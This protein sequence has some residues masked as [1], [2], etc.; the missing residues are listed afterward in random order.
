MAFIPFKWIFRTDNV[1]S[2]N[3]FTLLIEGRASSVSMIRRLIS[4]QAE[5]AGKI[6]IQS[7]FHKMFLQPTIDSKKGTKG[8]VKRK[9]LCLEKSLHI[10]VVNVLHFK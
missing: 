6:I 4:L 7:G 10:I 8:Q 2:S 5:P 1:I 9:Q 3:I